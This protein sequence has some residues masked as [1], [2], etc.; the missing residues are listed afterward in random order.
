MRCMHLLVGL[1]LT[2]AISVSAEAGGSYGSYGSG[3]SSGGIVNG[4][5]GGGLLSGLRARIAARHSGSHGSSGG[6]SLGSSGGNASSGGSSG[7]VRVASYSA[8]SGG[9][10]SGGASSGGASSGGASSGGGLFSRIHARI[11]ARHAARRAASHGSSGGY[12][13]ARSS[14]SSGGSTSNGSSGGYYSSASISSGSH[15]SSGGYSAPVS[16]AAPVQYSAPLI[17]SAPMIESSYPMESSY[18]SGTII[19]SSSYPIDGGVIHG[20]SAPMGGSV[21]DGAII[22]S[23]ASY[24]SQKPALDDDAALLTVAVPVEGARVTVNGHETTSDGMVRQFMSR[25]LKDGYLYT[26]EVIVTYDVEGR[27]MQ[28]SKTIKLRPGDMERMVFMQDE[29]AVSEEAASAPSEATQVSTPATVEATETVVQLY[30]PANAEVTLAGNK[31]SGFGRVRTF[32]TTQL[33]DGQSWKNYTVSVAA[34]VN[35]K[36]VRREQTVDVAAGDSVELTFDFNN[37]QT[38]AMR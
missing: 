38:I 21:I 8:S 34:T 23:G 26:Y 31:T 15:G 25:G 7:G 2:L 18:P 20:G 29:E 14:Y 13:V 16:Y 24:E 36:T 4:S 28:D 30:V 3:G 11:H 17:Q 6:Y 37:S 33:A 22:N 1:T 12:T 32:R 5:S 19:D 35:G 27:E 9:A 10:S